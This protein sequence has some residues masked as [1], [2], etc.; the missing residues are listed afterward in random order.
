MAKGLILVCDGLFASRSENGAQLLTPSSAWK[1]PSR[2]CGSWVQC[3]RRPHSPS[4]VFAWRA[5]DLVRLLA[6][7]LRNGHTGRLKTHAVLHEVARLLSDPGRF[8]PAS[9]VRGEAAT[10]GTSTIPQDGGGLGT[11]IADGISGVVLPKDSR[12]DGYA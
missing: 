9:M 6:G 3:V 7:A 5:T 2:A 8:E 10:L 4:A 12:V 1:L 11:T